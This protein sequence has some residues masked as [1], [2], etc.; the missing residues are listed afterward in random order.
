MSLFPS[1]S[2]QILIPKLPLNQKN[3]SDK[4]HESK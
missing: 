4:H 2:F 3:G 1:A